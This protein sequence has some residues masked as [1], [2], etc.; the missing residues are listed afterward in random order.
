VA[1]QHHLTVERRLK[2]LV[3]FLIVTRLL[4]LQMVAAIE[5]EFTADGFC[6]Q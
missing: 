4:L 3:P 6:A 1:V 5:V 2:F